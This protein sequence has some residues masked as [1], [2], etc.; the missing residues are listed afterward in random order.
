MN[1][2]KALEA[3]KR[4]VDGLVE[5]A[6]SVLATDRPFGTGDGRRPLP[7]SIFDLPT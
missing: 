4:L 5:Q 1:D 7:S 3:Y 6:P 2:P